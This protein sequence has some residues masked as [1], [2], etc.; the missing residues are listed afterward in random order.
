MCMFDLHQAIAGSGH[1]Q[2]GGEESGRRE[3][4][5]D[6]GHLRHPGGTVG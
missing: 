1:V 5:Q 2:V 3:G 4:E 6:G